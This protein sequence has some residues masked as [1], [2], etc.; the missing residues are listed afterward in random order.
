MR[1]CVP[2]SSSKETT[3][4]ELLTESRHLWDPHDFPICGK[5]WVL[6]VPPIQTYLD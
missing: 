3:G 6:K 1:Q 4:S 2:V 5:K